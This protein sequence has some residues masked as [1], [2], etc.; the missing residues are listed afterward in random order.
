[1]EVTETVKLLDEYGD[2][3]AEKLSSGFVVFHVTGNFDSLSE[4]ES[5]VE[6]VDGLPTA[7]LVLTGTNR[8]ALAIVRID[9][10]EFGKVPP[11]LQDG[12]KKTEKDKK[13]PS[14]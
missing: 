13:H 6:L 5:F 2:A 1:M 3:K 7:K 4:I 12:W 10:D 11:Y 9:I 14:R 8:D